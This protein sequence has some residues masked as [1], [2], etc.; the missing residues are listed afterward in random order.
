MGFHTWG[1]LQALPAITRNEV[2]VASNTHAYCN[3]ELIRF[4][5]VGSK[6]PL[7]DPVPNRDFLVPHCLVSICQYRVSSLIIL[8]VYV[9]YLVNVKSSIYGEKSVWLSL[10]IFYFS[11]ILFTCRIDKYRPQSTMLNSF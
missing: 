1:R 11:F 7:D 10:Q 4:C 2:T 9:Q 8:Q 3:T 6:E 5:R